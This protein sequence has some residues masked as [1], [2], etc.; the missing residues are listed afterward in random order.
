MAIAG[1]QS[2]S[3]SREERDSDLTQVA[4]DTRVALTHVRCASLAGHKED[5]VQRVL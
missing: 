5:R 1:A 4:R 2:S 3:S